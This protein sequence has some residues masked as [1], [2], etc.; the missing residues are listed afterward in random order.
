MGDAI[1]TVKAGIEGMRK[2]ASLPELRQYSEVL[3]DLN[4]ALLETQS[5]VFDN[6]ELREAID[7]KE[8]LI[9]E[10]RDKLKFAGK[11]KFY[12]G[13]YYEELDNGLLDPRA[14]CTNCW[15]GSNVALHLTWVS[16][17]FYGWECP[18]C[19]SKFHGQEYFK[20]DKPF[21]P[22]AGG[23]ESKNR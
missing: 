12:E 5:L 1:D 6:R 8:K 14:Y 7:E 11:I 22:N 17:G 3:T 13:L 15:E 20:H 19:S 10:L 9:A 23:S 4:A 16:Q 2:L 18:A 21:A